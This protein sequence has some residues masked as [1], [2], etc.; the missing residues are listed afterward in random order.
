MS[1]T[2]INLRVPRKYLALQMALGVETLAILPVKVSTKSA[3]DNDLNWT[4][5]NV[6]SWS[7]SFALL[8]EPQVAL[9]QVLSVLIHLNKRF[10]PICENNYIVW[11]LYYYM[12]NF[13]NLIGLEQWYFSLI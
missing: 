13:C 8:L 10:F 3:A 7:I 1:Q 5:L 12:R 11:L 9:A 6:E 4:S 2:G